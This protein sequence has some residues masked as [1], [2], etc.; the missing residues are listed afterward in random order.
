MTD[1]CNAKVVLLA[2]GLGTRLRPLT[3]H[4]PKCLIPIA[5]KPLLDYWF[6]AFSRAGLREVL[7]NNHHLPTQLRKYIEDKNA[8]GRFDVTEA[9]EP[10]LLG[11]A[12]TIAANSRFAD[13]AQDYFAWKLS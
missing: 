2:G 12:G 11:S 9:Y 5:D 13:G 8:S 3:D 6:E 4:T 10:E 1:T 7:I